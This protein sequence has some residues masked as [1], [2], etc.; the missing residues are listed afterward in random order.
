MISFLRLISAA[1]FQPYGMPQLATS[2]STAYWTRSS[3]VL[4]LSV[5]SGGYTVEYDFTISPVRSFGLAYIHPRPIAFPH[6]AMT[7]G[8]LART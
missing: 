3:T 5:H 7:D 2:A 6:Q 4:M 8:P 1:A